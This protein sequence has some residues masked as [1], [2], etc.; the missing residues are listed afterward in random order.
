MFSFKRK[1]TQRGSLALPLTRERR[2]DAR[3]FSRWAWLAPSM[4]VLAVLLV[5]A[6]LGSYPQYVA[7]LVISAMLTGTGLT[8]LVGYA[9]CISLA[10]GAVLALGAYGSVLLITAAGV[11][12]LP[13]MLGGALLAGLGG[14]VLGVP[15][16]RFRGHNLAM[17]TLV[18]QSVVIILIRESTGLTGGAG[19]LTVPAPSIAGISLSGDL[20]YL[21]FTAVVVALVLVLP[22][23]LLLGRFGRNLRAVSGNE[24]A[25]Q[26]FGISVPHHL[27]AAFV[28]SSLIIG[29]SGALQAPVFRVIDPDTFGINT[30]ISTLAYPIVGGMGS[31]WGGLAGG[32]VM[33]ALPEVLRGLADY[34]ELFFASLVLVTVLFF[35]GGIAGQ[36]FRLRHRHGDQ[37]TRES[38]PSAASP[39]A[40]P[41]AGKELPDT[42]GIALS[43]DGVG[44]QYGALKAVDDVS[45]QVR[46]GEI[47]GLMGPNGAG[48]TTLFNIVSGFVEGDRGAIR[49]HGETLPSG[50]PVTR[51]SHGL[52]RT[53]QHVAVF[54]EI[55]V[56]DNVAIGLGGN[57]IAPVLLGSLLDPFPGGDARRER[58]RI[59]AALDSVGLAHLAR[60]KAR[61]L[62]LGDQRRLEIARAIVSRPRLLLLDEPVSGVSEEETGQ[63]GLLLRRINREQGITM[64]LVE[65][66]IGFL[67]GMSDHITVMAAGRVVCEGEPASVIDDP[68]V[69]EVYFGKAGDA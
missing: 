6:R 51:M 34:L 65:H 2:V 33:R 50:S 67:A 66:N 47:R 1:S 14:F 16:V 28:C 45:F 36:L 55:S 21:V 25:A 40:R 56:Y 4:V 52:T 38:V 22:M 41:A 60:A 18:F 48:K 19:G 43:I 64:L 61:Q 63:L 54:G 37:V 5:T 32:A 20:A 24:V 46:E 27:V 59:M 3:G 68:A 53:F 12:L 29:L 10:T 17:I 62:S 13:A 23:A 42:A 49:L 7:S 58:A 11:P 35:P 44:K 39:V 9:R 15:A 57:G 26:A 8:L 69:Q 30:S 31:A